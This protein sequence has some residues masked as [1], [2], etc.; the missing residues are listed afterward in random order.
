[1]NYNFNVPPLFPEFVKYFPFFI[2][3]A[4]RVCLCAILP[5]MGRCCWRIWNEKQTWRPGDLDRGLNTEQAFKT[6]NI[7]SH[8]NLSLGWRKNTKAGA[9]YFKVSPHNTGPVSVYSTSGRARSLMK[10][11]PIYWRW[12]DPQISMTRGGVGWWWD[13]LARDHRAGELS[14]IINYCPAR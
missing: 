1:M 12:D 2:G 3:A 11:E 5:V 14:L 10:N 9:V 8:K 4:Q 7:S 6:S 13:L